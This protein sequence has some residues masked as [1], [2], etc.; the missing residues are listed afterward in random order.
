MVAEAPHWKRWRV[1]AAQAM[2]ESAVPIASLDDELAGTAEGWKH[3][4]GVAGSVSPGSKKVHNALQR[5]IQSS[6]S[7]AEFKENV[8]PWAEKYLAHGYDSLPPGFE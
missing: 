8:R 2:G 1:S 4:T 7:L 3:A 5:A 6:A